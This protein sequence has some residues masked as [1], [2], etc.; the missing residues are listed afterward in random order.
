[1]IDTLI[2]SIGRKWGKNMGHTYF[3]DIISPSNE[4]SYE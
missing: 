3:S 1:M 4:Q 2:E